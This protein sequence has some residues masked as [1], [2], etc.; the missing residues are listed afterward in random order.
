VDLYIK[1]SGQVML[2]SSI[3]TH[4]RAVKDRTEPRAPPL[5]GAEWYS[6]G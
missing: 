1:Y 4:N 6:A 2:M 5:E 3:P